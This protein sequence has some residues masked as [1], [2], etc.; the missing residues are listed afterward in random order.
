[1][2]ICKCLNHKKIIKKAISSYKGIKRRLELIAKT[3]N[4]LFFDDFAQ[5]PPRVK[6]SINTIKSKY[7]YKTI[8]VLFEPHASSLQNKNTTQHLKQAF[9]NCQEIILSKIS[10]NRNSDKTTRVTA[11]YYK[12]TIGKKLKYIPLYS[13]I[14][15]YYIKTLSSNDILIHMSSGGLIGIQTFNKIIKHF[16]KNQ[17]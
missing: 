2:Q 14:Y 13:N 10:F 15:T 8:K 4:I 1:M 9:K 3:K 6:S 17:L 16:K 5:S 7:P 11:K 12:N